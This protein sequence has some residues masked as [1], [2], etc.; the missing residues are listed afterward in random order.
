[1]AAVLLLIVVGSALDALKPW[2]M[3]WLLA[4]L[5]RE[6]GEAAGGSLDWLAYLPGSGSRAAVTLWLAAAGLVVY[7][8][9]QVT[10]LSLAY[11]QAGM[12]GRMAY[13]LGAAVF[14][15]VQELSLLFH[16][17][18]RVGDLVRRVI[19]DSGSVRDLMTTVVVPAATAGVSLVLMFVVMWRMDR[20]L[21]V[22][23]VGF[24]LP[25]GLL[26]RW[27]SRP[28]ADRAYR[29]Q[30]LEGEMAAHAEQTL[31]ALASVQLFGREPEQDR[32]FRE[33]AT[34]TRRAHLG[35]VWA[36]LRFKV[37][38]GAVTATGT[39]AV[40]MV[41]GLRVIDGALPVDSLVVFVAYVAS[42]YSPLEALA[43]T[44]AG[45][46]AASAGGRRVLEV[47]E[48]GQRIPESPGSRDIT[49]T[50]ALGLSVEFRK[51]TFGYNPD[52]PVLRDVELDIPAGEVVAL[53]GATGAGKS[54]LASLV[55]RLADTWA[56]QVRVGGSDVREL[57]L[58][59]L[60]THVAVVPQEPLLLPVSVRDNIAYGLDG[61]PADAVRA[62]AVSAGADEFVARLPHGYDTV[63][64]ERGAT[65]SVGQRQRI[66][67]ARAL[68]RGA[69]VIVLDEPTSALDVR[70]EQ[71]V[72]DSLGTALAGVTCI[73]IAHRLSTVRRADRIVVLDQGRVAEVGTHDQL[74]NVPGGMYRRLYE[75]QTGTTAN[76]SA[77]GVA[78]SPGDRP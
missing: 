8:L 71:D 42:L 38:T 51:V 26:I 12:G 24:A 56:G 32:R 34:R 64:G 50:T 47:L 55:P 65:L 62:A 27:L 72:V 67:I 36:Q 28:M 11:V 31:S 30:E 22:I 5:I 9:G 63:L 3:K 10:R 21:A 46:A 69:K 78:V 76:E 68:A 23:A 59:S 15:H 57:T 77:A 14:D 74:V 20:V 16:S 33:L 25:L 75:L 73:I 43:Y 54:T 61:L 40:V 58:R 6:R 41:G 52:S 53:V 17:K 37:G 2:P 7:A 18:R 29:Q 4:Y 13:R 70:T 66:A 19:T 45:F 1:M 35:S 60:R 44:S 48:S 49:L 39:A